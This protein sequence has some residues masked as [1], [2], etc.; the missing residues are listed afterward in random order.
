MLMKDEPQRQHPATEQHPG[1]ELLDQL[2]PGLALTAP[3]M[4]SIAST[5][6]PSGF[7]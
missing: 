5:M 3:A 2:K 1:N 7:A 4:M 6:L